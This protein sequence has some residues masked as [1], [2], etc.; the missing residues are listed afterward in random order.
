MLTGC[1]L[2]KYSKDEILQLGALAGSN[3]LRRMPG[4][5]RRHFQEGLP[6]LRIDITKIA[7]AARDVDCCV[8]TLKL[9]LSFFFSIGAPGTDLLTRPWIVVVG[10]T[11][12]D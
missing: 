1:I 2:N 12:G 5:E 3:N 8:D 6:F 11:Q 4:M 10:K 9:F 7:T